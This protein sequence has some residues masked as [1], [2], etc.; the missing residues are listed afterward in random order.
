MSKMFVAA[1]VVAIAGFYA[2]PSYADCAKDAA[3][4]KAMAAK[5]TDAKKKDMA[6]KHVMAAEGHVKAKMEKDCMAEVTKA[7]DSLK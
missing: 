7:K 5:A 4:V 2:A 3:D 1:I 6:M